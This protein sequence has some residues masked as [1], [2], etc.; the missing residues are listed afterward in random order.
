MNEPGEEDNSE[1]SAIVL[2]ELPDV[3]LEE[4]TTSDDSA[5][6]SYSQDQ[7]SDGYRQIS[8]WLSGCPLPCKNLDALL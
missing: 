2:D 8:S 4:R 1:R 7:E 3:A 5:Q 6:V